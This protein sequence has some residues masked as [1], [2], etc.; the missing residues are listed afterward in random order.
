MGVPSRTDLFPI[1]AS[2]LKKSFDSL[3][4]LHLRRQDAPVAILRWDVIE[5]SG[6]RKHE[7]IESRVTLRSIAIDRFP[8]VCD[9]VGH[10]AKK[11]EEAEGDVVK[12][13]LILVGIRDV[14]VPPNQDPFRGDEPTT[15]H[16]EVHSTSNVSTLSYHTPKL[17]EDYRLRERETLVRDTP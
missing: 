7:G 4:V 13:D 1:E 3:R 14:R 8:H 15:A 2:V 17:Y 12:S 9:A 5:V 10:L 11:G 16:H 6:V